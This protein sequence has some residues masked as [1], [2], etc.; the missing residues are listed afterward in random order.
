MGNLAVRLRR[1]MR[2][3]G[4]PPAMGSVD[5]YAQWAAN[6]PPHAHNALMQAE[7]DCMLSLLP[8]LSGQMVLDLAGGTGRYGHLVLARGAAR[9]ICIDNSPDMLAHNTLSARAC[10]SMDAVPLGTGSIDGVICALA[11]GHVRD[12]G[13][14]FSEMARVLRPGGWALVSDFHPY[15]YLNGARRTFSG[16]DGRVHAVEHHIHLAGLVSE[17]SQSAGLRL[18][19]IR[20]PAL[21]DDIAPPAMR[22]R[23][24]VVVYRL[25]RAPVLEDLPA[26]SR[27]SG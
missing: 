19:A 5:A 12:I 11:I 18:D 25:F 20:E 14:V 1:L 27:Q 22:G 8:P 10:A 24:V 23:P 4:E 21:P 9:V 16:T 7:Q 2:A 17:V 15:A 3:N 6:Y 13:A 26:A